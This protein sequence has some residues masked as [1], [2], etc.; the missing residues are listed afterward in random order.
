M[1]EHM[2]CRDRISGWNIVLVGMAVLAALALYFGLA[3][4]KANACTDPC[5][6]AYLDLRNGDLFLSQG[7]PKHARRYTWTT[8]EQYNADARRICRQHGNRCL[9]DKQLGFSGNKTIKSA[10]PLASDKGE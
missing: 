3:Q 5:L 8:R 6:N 2:I 4:S 10:D 1:G 7:R 9:T